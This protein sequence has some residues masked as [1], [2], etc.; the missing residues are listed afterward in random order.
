MESKYDFG[1][2]LYELRTRKNL[3][4]KELGRLLGVSNKAVSKWET[5]EAK[6]R[7]DTMNKL[8]RI[9]GISVGELMGEESEVAES[10]SSD[11]LQGYESYF[12]DEA[13]KLD[14]RFKRAKVIIIII[15][16]GIFVGMSVDN[17][18]QIIRGNIANTPFLFVPFLLEAIYT[19]ITLRYISR[20]YCSDNCSKN[21]KVSKILTFIGTSALICGII[22]VVTYIIYNKGLSSEEISAS[23]TVAEF[24][25]SAIGAVAL[26]VIGGLYKKNSK[27]ISKRSSVYCTDLLIVVLAICAITGF[28][29][30]MIFAVLIMFTVR[31]AFKKFEWLELAK[32]VNNN[33][34]EEKRQV[35]KKRYIIL[36]AV[37]CALVL[38]L[39][40]S[41]LLTPYIMYKRFYSDLPDYLKQPAEE[42]NNYDT[43]FEEGEY[44][45]IEFENITF[46]CPA[47]WE[48]EYYENDSDYRSE[49]YR[50]VKYINKDD[51]ISMLV[52]VDENYSDLVTVSQNDYEGLDEDD[53]EELREYERNSKR[54]DKL[55]E[56]Y[57]NIPLD[58][59]V[60]QYNYLMYMVDL[61]GVKWYQTEKLAT[62]I[63]AI[64]MKGVIPTREIDVEFFETND[65]CGFIS[66]Q[67]NKGNSFE[68]T[69][70]GDN[71]FSDNYCHIM[72]RFD[73]L[74][75][76]ESRTLMGKIL[77]SVKFN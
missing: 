69:I 44:Q 28:C 63:S 38:F 61:R 8:A 52:S 20:I 50:I 43:H 65:K 6:P 29:D 56:K 45:T 54:L 74:S 51:G 46:L 72:L 4:Q 1:N 71:G 2:R 35:N 15:N 19:L 5:G 60:Y 30:V 27:V 41:Y 49:V 13:K 76:E 9:L 24:V 77:N 32:K 21:Q 22:D 11:Q 70:F 26:I 66:H 64:I 62:Y 73:N 7:V 55:Y 47:E 18:Y 53:K 36:S 39:S 10:I 17:I 33:Y 42:Y 3:T 37:A 31:A 57:F 68:I 14:A 67:Y 25:I 58:T 12:T 59:N 34:Y 75:E 23:E 16:F 40:F 48:I